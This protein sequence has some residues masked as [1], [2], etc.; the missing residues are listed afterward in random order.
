MKTILLLL[1]VLALVGCDP[2]G[3]DPNQD[4]EGMDLPELH[5]IMTHDFAFPYSCEDEDSDLEGYDGAA[6]FLSGLSFDINSPELLYDGACGSTNYFLVAAGGKFGFI[7]DLGPVE[8]ESL[9]ANDWSYSNEGLNDFQPSAEVV[10]GHTYAVVSATGE[11]RALF[12]FH[13]DEFEQD[14]EASIRYA[15][16]FYEVYDFRAQSEGFDWDQPSE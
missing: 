16:K 3:S 13:V 10:E 4:L 9:T 7:A 12:Y 15:V 5:Q 8:L 11:S 6:L 14:G 1:L 2:E